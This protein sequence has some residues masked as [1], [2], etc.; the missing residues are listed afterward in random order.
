M[1]KPELKQRRTEADPGGGLRGFSNLSGYP[2]LSLFQTK[3]NI[4]SHNL[5]SSS[6]DHYKKTIA[7]A[8]LGSF[9][10]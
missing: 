3:N 8:L 6:I 7:F 2:C 10:I 9:I 4:I 5:S 1:L